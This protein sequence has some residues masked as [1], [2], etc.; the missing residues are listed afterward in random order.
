M[1][2]SEEVL[3]A[4]EIPPDPIAALTELNSAG[5]AYAIAQKARY[6]AMVAES[7]ALTKLNSVQKQ[8]DA[9]YKQ[10]RN[11]APDGSF[12]DDNPF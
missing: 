4:S 11:S 9:L 10:L 5:E 1:P 12:W 3:A 7:T 2:L 8:F 6:D